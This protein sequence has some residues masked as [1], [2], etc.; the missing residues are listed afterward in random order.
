MRQAGGLGVSTWHWKNGPEKTRALVHADL[1]AGRRASAPSLACTPGVLVLAMPPMLSRLP[2]GRA[3]SSTS[4]A[5]CARGLSVLTSPVEGSYATSSLRRVPSAARP[6]AM[7][8]TPPEAAQA[9]SAR[10]AGG[11]R[12]QG[13]RCDECNGV[14]WGAKIG[15]C[16]S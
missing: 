15:H 4:P 7:Y 12:R 13:T 16:K 11:R 6:P 8:R 5:P 1:A 14:G 9:A 3:T 10:A 2:P